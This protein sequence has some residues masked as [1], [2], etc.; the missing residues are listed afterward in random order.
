M[1]STGHSIR[2]YVSLYIHYVYVYILRLCTNMKIPIAVQNCLFCACLF[3]DCP[4]NICSYSALSSYYIGTYKLVS[5]N[6]ALLE[7]PGERLPQCGIECRKETGGKKKLRKW[8]RGHQFIVRAGG[9][10][11]AW[12]PIYKYVQ[13]RGQIVV[14]VLLI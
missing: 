3:C 4:R 9:H 10:I 13:I 11:D 14:W 7:T 6:P 1:Y 5:E 8:S 2:M 12:Q